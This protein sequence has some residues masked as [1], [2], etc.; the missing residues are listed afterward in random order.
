[1]TIK[2]P[3]SPITDSE[4]AAARATPPPH[5]PTR[6]RCGRRSSGPFRMLGVPLTWI[7]ACFNVF[8]L[9]WVILTAFRNGSE[10]FT[11]P[12]QLPRSLDPKNFTDAWNSSDLGS[13]F[14][15]SVVI[16]AAAATTVIALSAPAAYV[17]SRG[18]RRSSE[19]ITMAF[20][21]G[22]GIP[23]QAVIIPVFVW[24]QNISTYMYDT[25]GWW[26]ERISLYLIYVASSLPFTVY[27]LTGFF[28]SLP[29]ELEEAAALDG[30]SSFRTFRV[31]MLPLARPG[32]VT[33][34]I[35]LVISLWNETLLALVLITE[36]DKYTL[37]QALLGLYGTMQYT[38]NWGGLFAGI[39]IVVL[40]II[41]VYIWLGR[42]IVEGLTL[43]A[44][45]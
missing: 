24:M 3:D 10:I 27:L 36:T 26:D 19:L 13:G 37:P 7:W 18:Q 4:D 29:R 5:G 9:L 42:R 39:V 32:I 1:M 43:G 35:L 40:P 31:V 45:K 41:A 11:D 21:A 8:L 2:L 17:L 33:A 15:N 6:S 28:R 25:F 44:G 38:S 14:M 20:V 16:V 30:C 34:T 12:F 23:M 22:M